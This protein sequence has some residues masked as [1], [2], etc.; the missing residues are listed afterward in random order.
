[1]Y[2]VAFTTVTFRNLLRSNITK[3]AVD[4]DIKN[5]EWGGDVHLPVGDK[6][7]IDEVLDFNNNFGLQ[8]LSYGSYYRVGSRDYEAFKNIVDTAS[9]IGAKVIRVWLGAVSSEK[10]T[11]CLYYE[12][13][14]EVQNIA[15]IAKVKGLK[16]AFEFH[17]GTY[18]DSANNTITFLSAVHRDNVGTYWQPLGNRD[19]DEQNLI[20]VIP[21]LLGIHV[22]NWDRFGRRHSLKTG[23][24][25][26]RKYIEIVKESKTEIP[27]IIEFVKNDKVK[28]F[29]KDVKTLNKLLKDCYGR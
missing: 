15:D 22:F 29:E 26:W 24:K 1:M 10:T 4:C 9:A 23:M 18:N 6:K 12:M 14:A 8:S 2:K 27:F 17:C 21:Y 13:V 3:I 20:K 7:A 5:I 28:Q 16:I 11:K 25:K 19:E